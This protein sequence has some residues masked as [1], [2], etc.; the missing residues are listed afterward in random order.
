MGWKSNEL[1]NTMNWKK[2]LLLAVSFVVLAWVIQFSDPAAVWASVKTIP[3]YYLFLFL[4]PTVIANFLRTYRWAGLVEPVKKLSFRQALPYQLAGL[5]MSNITPARIGEAG[6]VLLLKKYEGLQ[7]SKTIQSVIWERLFD[8]VVLLAIS[9]P[10]LGL[11]LGKLE[12]GLML[13]SIIGSVAVLAACALVFVA[14]R[15]Q[16]VGFWLLGFAEKLPV[17]KKYVTRK[18]VEN[19]Y[20]TAKL[21]SST[22]WKS[23]LLTVLI[24]AIDSFA[25]VLVFHAMGLP[26]PILYIYGGLFLSVLIG[27]V[28]FLPGGIGSSEFSFIV[29][30]MLLGLE[31]GAAAAGVLVGRFFTLGITLVWGMLYLAYMMYK[32]Q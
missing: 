5:A 26:I 29:I 15:Y 4:M 17:L 20:G 21:S 7:V 27:L 13:L 12:P 3:R 31:K 8:L 22:F 1:G 16:K 25:F 2:A 32:G 30:L 10:F 6:K 19:F 11:L 24:W 18:F 23:A 9:L 28:S 14:M